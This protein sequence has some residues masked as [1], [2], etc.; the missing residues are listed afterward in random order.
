M[1]NKI[2]F[3]LKSIPEIYYKIFAAS[4]N[5]LSISLFLIFFSILLNNS[6]KEKVIEKNK[7]IQD[8]KTQENLILILKESILKIDQ[9]QYD[10][11]ELNVDKV[12][13]K[14]ESVV[15]KVLTKEGENIE[16][17]ENEKIKNIKEVELNNIIKN[18]ESKIENLTKDK[19]EEIKNIQIEKNK[20]KFIYISKNIEKEMNVVISLFNNLEKEE[21]K[22]KKSF[23]EK[24]NI[25]YKS[26]WALVLE[27]ENGL[28]TT[29]KYFN[30]I[31]LLKRHLDDYKELIAIESETKEK[32]EQVSVSF[33]EIEKSL[34]KFNDIYRNIEEEKL[35]LIEKVLNYN[36]LLVMLFLL[37]FGGYLL[38][39]II[40]ANEVILKT[41]KEME[42]IL[43]SVQEGLFLLDKEGVIGSKISKSTNQIMGINL[44]SG[45]NLFEAMKAKV[46]D[47][48]LRTMIKFIGL[49]FNGKIK[50]KLI[51][52][53][54]PVSTLEIIDLEKNGQAKKKYLHMNFSRVKN[55]KSE[56]T[57][58]I[59]VTVLDN[60]EKYLLEQKIK[61]AEVLKQQEFDIFSNLLNIDL[62]DFEKFVEKI[63][64][65]GEKMNTTLKSFGESTLRSDKVLKELTEWSRE[66][67]AMKG[68][69]NV[70]SLE[71]IAQLLHDLET[72]IVELKKQTSYIGKDFLSIILLLDNIFNY[73]IEVDNIK[74]KIEKFHKK[75]KNL[76]R[77]YEQDF[78]KNEYIELEKLIKKLVKN[79]SKTYNKEINTIIDL[80]VLS[81]YDELNSF[82]FLN[83]FK[84]IL[85]QL[86]KNAVVHGFET[87]KER[88]ESK[89]SIQGTFLL[90]AFINQDMLKI[91]IKDDG[92]GLNIKK[93][94]EQAINLGY[95]SPNSEITTEQAIKFITLSGFSTQ[96]N[97]NQEAGRG[98]GL[99][100]VKNKIEQFEGVLNI[101]T[102]KN[103][104]T[105]FEIT[106]NLNK[107][108]NLRLKNK[109][110]DVINLI[111]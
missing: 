6:N 5:F 46:S 84:N 13:N 93:I 67:H 82:E 110:E 34:K 10:L 58:Q 71:K 57:N 33:L 45:I 90:S 75:N 4:F 44:S 49:L 101:K 3:F 69:A 52:S 89:K 109:K 70:L 40:S 92:A 23:D 72:K 1:L 55:E 81:E 96:E 98:F 59:L 77:M 19:N 74:E 30:Q 9:M 24:G 50:E 8:L 25:D 12:D 43:D 17:N 48:T 7:I 85:I 18:L 79:L 103:V 22:I 97:V 106:F 64:V 26:H 73:L 31:S 105:L 87:T 60:T 100:M 102:G 86:S 32:L 78:S 53:L 66:I 95:L 83:E 38:I 104:G 39:K 47:D 80:K 76:A 107:M 11:K 15:L 21:I 56:T 35:N 65:Y 88:L 68:E 29:F 42:K 20:D 41:E 108:C 111:N 62:K 27:N 14:N 54:N 99:D 28:K 37:M 16:K 94:K 51:G 91:L 36:S 61:N 2:N 63:K